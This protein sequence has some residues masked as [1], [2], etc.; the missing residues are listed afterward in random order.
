MDCNWIKININWCYTSTGFF[1]AVNTEPSSSEPT[2]AP[3]D[4]DIFRDGPLY[5]PLQN[6]VDNQDTTELS[7]SNIEKIYN[8]DVE[9]RND[10]LNERLE[11]EPQNVF[12]MFDEKDM[13][14][15]KN[16]FD[17]NDREN[18]FIVAPGEN[19]DEVSLDAEARVEDDNDDERVKRSSGWEKSKVKHILLH[20][21]FVKKYLLTDT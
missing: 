9:I 2:P 1:S 15:V 14:Y 21:H 13:S 20:I 19:S 7:Q 12:E 3:L 11:T 16:P 17:L 10:N 6:P 5:P 18:G 4:A 8:Q